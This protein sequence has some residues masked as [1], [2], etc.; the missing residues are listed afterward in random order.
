MTFIDL[1]GIGVGKLVENNNSTNLWVVDYLPANTNPVCEL[2]SVTAEQGDTIVH[3]VKKWLSGSGIQPHAHQEKRDIQFFDL[4]KHNPWLV[5]V[6]EDAHLI[7]KKSFTN[8][9]L[10][11]EKT[12]GVILQGDI[13]A[14]GAKIFDNDRFMQRVDIGVHV[15]DVFK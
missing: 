12:R 13:L 11:A 9:S 2:L 1:R 10:I 8:F 15:N 14:L 6:V 7:S 4:I 3:I 5:L